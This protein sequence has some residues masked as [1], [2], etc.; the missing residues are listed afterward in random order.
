MSKPG[1]EIPLSSLTIEQLN[2]RIINFSALVSTAPRRDCPNAG[3][4][5]AAT[6]EEKVRRGGSCTWSEDYLGWLRSSDQ[7]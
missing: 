7:V 5:L 2:E 1:A 4:E 6:L 3:S